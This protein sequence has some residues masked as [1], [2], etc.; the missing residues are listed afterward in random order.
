MED[1]WTVSSGR[2]TQTDMTATLRVHEGPATRAL[3][4]S[5]AVSP[6]R[7]LSPS[8]HGGVRC[9]AVDSEQLSVCSHEEKR[10]F[11]ISAVV[12]PR[13]GFHLSVTEVTT[14]VTPP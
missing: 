6:R 11:Y 5:G 10:R 7:A 12:D 9:Q 2:L 3:S 14:V 8:L 4:P 13:N 1:S